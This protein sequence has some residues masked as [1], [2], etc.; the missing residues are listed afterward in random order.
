MF[1]VAAPFRADPLS[2]QFDC[3]VWVVW[4]GQ[5]VAGRTL[6][7]PSRRGRRGREGVPLVP[8]PPTRGP[9]ECFPARGQSLVGAWPEGAYGWFA[10]WLLI[11][12]MILPQVH[13]RNGEALQSLLCDQAPRCRGGP[14]IS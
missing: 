4:V 3:V 8:H 14:T 5:G 9:N 2:L 11:D 7:A 12:S 6:P 13:L 10:V 1:V